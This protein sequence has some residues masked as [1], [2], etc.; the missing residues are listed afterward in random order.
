[1]Q[2]SFSDWGGNILALVGLLVVNGLETGMNLGGQT[3]GAISAK[4]PALFT[5]QLSGECLM[6]LCLALRT[7][8]PFFVP[9]GCAA[10]L[11]NCGLSQA[12]K[13]G[14]NGSSFGANV[15]AVAL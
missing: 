4:Y 6:D 11:I 9:H 10:G 2:R 15:G 12:G 5:P 3:T 7:I 13:R 1:M 14:Q 8:G